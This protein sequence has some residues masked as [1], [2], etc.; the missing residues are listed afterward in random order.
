MITKKKYTFADDEDQDED[1]EHE[2]YEKVRKEMS[3]HLRCCPDVGHA[4]ISYRVPL[5]KVL[6]KEENKNIRLKLIDSFYKLYDE[7]IRK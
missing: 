4:D 6:R 5:S 7:F 3:E 1:E 2:L